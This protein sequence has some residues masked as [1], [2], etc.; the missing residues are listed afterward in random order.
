MDLRSRKL[1]NQLVLIA[2]LCSFAMDGCATA[3][4][5]TSGIVPP[6]PSPGSDEEGDYPAWSRVTSVLL[7]PFTKG[8]SAD[9]P[10]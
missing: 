5:P 6:R 2:A 1:R 7:M 3:D 9:V 10:F 8:V 4:R